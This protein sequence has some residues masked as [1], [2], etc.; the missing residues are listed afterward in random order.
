MLDTILD[1]IGNSRVIQ[2]SVALL[3]AISCFGLFLRWLL[4]WRLMEFIRWDWAV[5]DI[6]DQAPKLIRTLRQKMIDLSKRFDEVNTN[7]LVDYVLAKEKLFLGLSLEQAE[8]WTQIIPNILISLGLLGTFFGITI[9]LASI[10]DGL[11]AFVEVN[12]GGIVSVAELIDKFRQPL[13]GMAFAFITSLVGL[14][15]GVLLTII[16]SIYNTALA[17][18]HFF[19][20]VEL[21]LD[22]ELL[23]QERNSTSRLIKSISDNFRVFLDN[24][25]QA[26]TVAIEHPLEREMGRIREMNERS[27]QLAEKVYSCFDDAAGNLVA[28][29]RVFNDAIQTLERSEF[30]AKFN[31]SV[32]QLSQHVDLLTESERQSRELNARVVALTQEVSSVLNKVN[33]NQVNFQRI[34][35]HLS[36]TTQAFIHTEQIIHNLLNQIA[37]VDRQVASKSE[38]LSKVVER[39]ENLIV[40]AQESQNNFSSCFNQL[41]SIHRKIGELLT[42]EA[43]QYKSLVQ[44]IQAV[45]DQFAAYQKQ[46]V[47]F[48]QIIEQLNATN[49]NLTHILT[50]IEE[51]TLS[52]LNQSKSEELPKITNRLEYLVSVATESKRNLSSRS[53]DLSLIHVKVTE[54]LAQERNQYESLV[55]QI[56]AVNDQF[57]AYQK[58]FD[59]KLDK[60]LEARFRVR[61]F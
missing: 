35:E 36:A 38:E 47:E 26:V 27:A 12:P 41:S 10:K 45:N 43:S 22:Y 33:T 42:H 7:V 37:T 46:M 11:D 58:Q 2:A 51:T 50:H 13:E 31:A 3:I 5:K 6:T 49:K 17:K 4:F 59:E 54:L 55:Q 34:A 30:V 28:S 57:A 18:R 19:T 20:A 1:Q 61:L 39:L 25:Y 40:F 52:L 29:S 32:Q 15:L 9:S 8:F 21:Y 14:F 60:L 44:Q 23:G 16:N 24:F 53:D 56:R 48:H